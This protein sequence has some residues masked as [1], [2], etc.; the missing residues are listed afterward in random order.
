MKKGRI[1]KLSDF[2]KSPTKNNTNSNNQFLSE[3]EYKITLYQNIKL[4]TRLHKPF[5]IFL[6]TNL[7]PKLS[8]TSG[9]TQSNHNSKP[10][11]GL[12]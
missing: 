7:Y 6:P 4:Q 8:L 11:D 1:K 12:K 3:T 10:L 5:N 9:Y 2:I